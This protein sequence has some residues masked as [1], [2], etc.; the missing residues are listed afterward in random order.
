MSTAETSQSPTRGL[1]ESAPPDHAPAIDPSP[2][3]P[4]EPVGGST[5]VRRR[6]GH[7]ATFVVVVVGLVVTIAFVLVTWSV[8]DANEQRLL[9]Q[10]TREAAA[11]LTAFLPSVQAPLAA[12][13]ETV[14]GTDGTDQ[15]TFDR[16]MTP[17]VQPGA[18]YVSASLWRTDGDSLEPLRVVGE[19][20]EL[21]SQPPEVIRDFL[22]ASA[23]SQNI[24]VIGL[25]NS[26]VPRLG[27][28]S[29]SKQTPA[30]FIAYAEAPLPANRTSVVRRDSAF[31]GLANAIYLGDDEDP[32]ELLTATTPDLPLTGHRVSERVPFGN[33][34]LLLVMSSTSE[35]GGR[36]MAWLPWLVGA[37]GVVATFGTALFTERLLRRR[38]QAEQ[39]A[40]V[41][42]YLYANQRSVADTLQQSLLPERLPEIAG[43]D[44]GFRYLPGAS[45]VDIGGDWY[46]VIPLGGDSL[47]MVVGDVSGRGVRAGAVMASLRFAIRAFASQGDTPA[48]ILTKLTRLVDLDQEG[49]FATVLCTSVNVVGH[50]VTV[51]NAGHPNPLL[52]TGDSASFLDTP[53]GVPVGVIPD[54]VYESV[55]L[56]VPERATLLAFTDGLFER[57]GETIDDGLERLRRDVAGDGRPLE[58]LLSELVAGQAS[59]AGH[60]DVAILA[61]RWTQ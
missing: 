4:D 24:S 57:R 52:I 43:V 27:Y 11:V 36:L 35:L 58:L 40:R 61:V 46:D 3:R 37:V 26:D 47:M 20:P 6:R 34:S 18:R 53:V 9:R 10:R 1:S 21:A 23:A 17:L 42:A 60:D 33:T 7:P 22:Q 16:L 54:A 15:Q 59:D 56:S 19:A 55:T 49:H 13:A 8:H 32:A 41:N 28:A 31:A 44:L 29:A 51:A 2:G 45:G 25:L 39:L 30:G 38:D 5:L 12:A 14:E 48:T 50:T